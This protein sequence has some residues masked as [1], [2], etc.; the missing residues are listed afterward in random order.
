LTHHSAKLVYP[1]PRRARRL[2][3]LGLLVLTSWRLRSSLSLIPIEGF[4]RRPPRARRWSPSACVGSASSGGTQLTNRGD[5]RCHFPRDQPGRAGGK[6]V[7][8]LEPPPGS[9]QRSGTARIAGWLTPWP[10]SALILVGG[11][12]SLRP[13]TLP[14]MF[15][16]I[17]VLITPITPTPTAVTSFL[18]PT[19][20]P[21]IDPSQWLARRRSPTTRHLGSALPWR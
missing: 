1:R 16:D 13:V 21:T 14:V 8:R 17:A 5:S 18:L 4:P 2:L 9:A 20:P 10:L 19:T 15:D 3:H 7:S 11:S 12:W 6:V